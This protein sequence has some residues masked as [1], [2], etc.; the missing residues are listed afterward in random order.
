M[1]LGS[2]IHVCSDHK[3]ITHCLSSF[4]TQ[5]VLCWIILLKEYNLTFHCYICGPQN[6]VTDSLGCLNSTL[7]TAFAFLDIIEPAIDDPNK[8]FLFLNVVKGLT[9]MPSCKAQ[10]SSHPVKDSYLFHP[11]FDPSS[12]LPF[13]F[14][15][16][17]HYQQND[18]KLLKL[19]TINNNQYFITELNALPIICCYNNTSQ[20]SWKIVLLISMLCLLINW[21]HKMIMHSTGIE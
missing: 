20:T 6:T 5:R 19:R 2:K 21:Y 18:P 13:H 9:A 10:T 7:T 17:H 4:T 14:Q 1:L 16:I 3:N 11:K 12:L 15:A 8:A